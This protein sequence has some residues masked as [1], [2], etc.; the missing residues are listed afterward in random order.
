M[1]GQRAVELR[2]IRAER[3]R[4]VGAVHAR[5]PA[6]TRECEHALFRGQL[7]V[8]G[9]PHAAVPLVDAAPVGAPQAGRHLGW[10]WGL[11]AGHRLELRPQCPVRQ[12]LEQGGGCG[13]V[14]AGSGQDPA[15]VLDHIRAGPG[16]L[17]QL[18]QRDRLLRGPVHLK[19]TG[20]RAGI[21]RPARTRACVSPALVPDRRRDRRQAHAERARERVRPAGV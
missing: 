3:P 11:Q 9:V 1:S 20:D 21:L 14:P 8:R 5:R 19:L 4:G 18:R 15:Q 6:D 13:G 16:A 2:Q 7:R 17:V 12:V 10:L